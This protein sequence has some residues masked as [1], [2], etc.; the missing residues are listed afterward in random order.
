MNNKLITLPRTASLL[1]CGLLLAGC[2]SAPQTKAGVDMVEGKHINQIAADLKT[3]MAKQDQHDQLLKEWQQL[4]P[5]ISR[6]LVI[7]EELNLMINQLDQLSSTSAVPPPVV[8][9]AEVVVPTVKPITPPKPVPQQT[10][11][12][13]GEANFALQITSLSDPIRLP[14]V[15]QKLKKQHPQLMSELVANYQKISVNNSDY[16]RLKLGAFASK[17]QAVSKCAELKA[18]G[19]NCLVTNYNSSDFSELNYM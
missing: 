17:Q 16:Y 10:P 15:W 8:A 1:I 11:V 9:K 14:V 19:I 13:T 12:R 7:E 6:M 4:K 5:A 18:K 3:I 2:Q